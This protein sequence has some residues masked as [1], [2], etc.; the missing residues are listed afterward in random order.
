MR[1]PIPDVYV[2]WHPRYVRGEP[3]ARRIHAWLRP[4]NSFPLY[5]ILSHLK[6]EV[7]GLKRSVEHDAD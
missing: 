2:L 6:V 1:T 5:W 4:G 7:G 3:L